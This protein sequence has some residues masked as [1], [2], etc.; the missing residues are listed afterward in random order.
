M[1]MYERWKVGVFGVWD[2]CFWMGGWSRVVSCVLASVHGVGV[3]DVSRNMNSVV[4]HS[5]PMLRIDF[6]SRGKSIYSVPR[7]SA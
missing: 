3:E 6:D 4:A 2:Y 7:C 1:S 5:N